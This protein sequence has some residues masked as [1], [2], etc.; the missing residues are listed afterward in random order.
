MTDEQFKAEKAFQAVMS[1][2]RAMLKQGIISV[3]DLARI[4]ALMEKKYNPPIGGIIAQYP[5]TS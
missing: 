4:R 5:L 3:S 2:A 1:I